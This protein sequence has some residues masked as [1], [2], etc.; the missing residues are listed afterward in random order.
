MS[1]R[2]RLQVSWRSVRRLLLFMLVLAVI[3]LSC[4][5]YVRWDTQ[6]E[7]FSDPQQL[8]TR[9]VA[10]VFGAGIYPD[11]RLSDMLR[12]RVRQAVEA[13]HLGR[14]QKLLMTGD[15]S[16]KSYDE[17]TAMQRYAISLG[18]PKAAI[19]L[20]YAGFSTYESCYRAKEI[21]GVRDAVLI[22]QGYHLPRAVYTCQQLGI[23]AI[24]LETN[25]RGIY[26]VNLMR[27]YAVREV[28]ATAKALWDVAIWHPLPT[29]LGP[30]E[31]MGN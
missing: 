28:A 14:V 25:D 11:G 21:F 15:N 29:F 6:E 2:L 1:A 22:T 12:F 16:R 7:R 27:Y 31:G 3:P 24:G 23:D 5:F 17:V 8:P 30:Y 19:R 13:Y 4:A 20:D 18:V 10:I 26:P 9:S